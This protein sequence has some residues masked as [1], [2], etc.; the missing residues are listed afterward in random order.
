[1]YR[2][3]SDLSFGSVSDE[4]DG[5]SESTFAVVSAGPAESIVSWRTYTNELEDLQDV[6][7]FEADEDQPGSELSVDSP[8]SSHAR[9]RFNTTFEADKD[10]RTGKKRQQRQDSDL[11]TTWAA[12]DSTDL[13]VVAAHLAAAA[14]PPART[15][16]E[17]NQ[18]D[19]TAM[20]LQT[21]LEAQDMLGF[22]SL[23]LRSCTLNRQTPALGTTQRL[24]MK[25]SF[26][27]AFQV[28]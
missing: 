5:P 13:G 26:S 3:V 1:M 8:S 6:E 24:N 18:D 20:L 14:L 11:P 10:S 17:A 23:D 16:H 2:E 25:A 9:I 19:A 22:G 21:P 28:T 15:S 4:E 27:M 7:D 12:C